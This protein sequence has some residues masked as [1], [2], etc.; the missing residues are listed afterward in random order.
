VIKLTTKNYKRKIFNNVVVPTIAA[1]SFLLPNVATAQSKETSQIQNN[2]VNYTLLE[3]I[4]NVGSKPISGKKLATTYGSGLTEGQLDKL[5]GDHLI[6]YKIVDSSKGIYVFQVT[7]IGEQVIRSYEAE[8]ATQKQAAID[9]Q[10]A[11]EAAQRKAADV[12]AQQKR[13][14]EDARRAQQEK[15]RNANADAMAAAQQTQEKTNKVTAAPVQNTTNTLTPTPAPVE[16]NAAVSVD[17]R[18]LGVIGSKSKVDKHTGK[19][20]HEKSRSAKDI[21][22][23]YGAVTEAQMNW[24]I[25]HGYVVKDGSHYALTAKARTEYTAEVKAK[26]AQH[27]AAA[28]LAAKAALLLAANSPQNITARPPTPLTAPKPAANSGGTNNNVQ[29]NAKAASTGNATATNQSAGTSK[30]ATVAPT[31]KVA[32]VTKK[33]DAKAAPSKPAAA[34]STAT[35]QRTWVAFIPDFAGKKNTNELKVEFVLPQ[36]RGGVDSI[37]VRG[38]TDKNSTHTAVITSNGSTYTFGHELF[39]H[40][41]RGRKEVEEHVTEPAEKGGKPLT[42]NNFTAK[43]GDRVQVAITIMP[44]AVVT[45]VTNKTNGTWAAYSRKTDGDTTFVIAPVKAEGIP[46]ATG[47]F[48]SHIG[49][50]DFAPNIS[51]NVTN[52][53]LTK[54]DNVQI[55]SGQGS[56]TQ[57]DLEHGRLGKPLYR[58]MQFT[59]S[60]DTKLW[61]TQV[62]GHSVV[63]SFTAGWDG[64]EVKLSTTQFGIW[65]SKAPETKENKS[66]E[67]ASSGGAAPAPFSSGTVDRNAIRQADSGEQNRT[68]TIVS[69]GVR[70]SPIITVTQNEENTIMHLLAA[71]TRGNQSVSEQALADAYTAKYNGHIDPAKLDATLDQLRREGKVQ[72][73]KDSVTG[74]TMIT[75]TGNGQSHVYALNHKAPTARRPVVSFARRDTRVI[76]GIAAPASAANK[77]KASTVSATPPVTVPPSFNSAPNPATNTAQHVSTPSNKSTSWSEWMYNPY[78]EYTGAGIALGVALIA[79][80]ALRRRRS[81][82]DNKRFSVVPPVLN[83]APATGTKEKETDYSLEQWSQ[84][85]GEE[86]KRSVGEGYDTSP[87]IDYTEGTRPITDSTTPTPK[88]ARS[89]GAANDWLTEQMSKEGTTTSP[90]DIT[91]LRGETTNGSHLARVIAAKKARDPATNNGSYTTPDLSLDEKGSTAAFLEAKRADLERRGPALRTNDDDSQAPKPNTPDR[92][93]EPELGSGNEEE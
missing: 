26:E 22:T 25:S 80:V 31:P 13:E 89:N 1:A 49:P 42:E 69:T 8:R 40:V 9:A 87:I 56:V 12:A 33:Q 72:L 76:G 58:D 11:R 46:H 48:V 45:T 37:A 44:G 30:S 82:N 70:A 38:E 10:N 23:G 6:S 65:N 51:F 39:H 35:Q 54:A 7:G 21:L 53:N 32:T 73:T 66:S 77:Q 63:P 4:K 15:Q 34:Q 84:Q 60:L 79:G 64:V 47:V 29:P 41:K 83:I 61:W 50:G 71:I 5:A 88:I 68:S 43:A 19:V 78:V 55:L 62:N 57:D 67:V 27:Q 2:N 52:F 17:Y 28:Q 75:I 81:E 85:K 24:Y 14:A 36:N 91:F 92:L 59:Q 90:K 18:L 86:Q 74:E 20:E 3:T 16:T 93:Q